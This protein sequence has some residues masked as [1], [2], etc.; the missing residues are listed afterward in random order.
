MTSRP[1]GLWCRRN[2][3]IVVLA[4]RHAG[5][6][7]GLPA[8]QRTVARRAEATKIVSPHA[9][10]QT[11]LHLVLCVFDVFFLFSD[12]KSHLQEGSVRGVVELEV[13]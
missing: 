8:L 1:S 4:R 7:P 12:L 10:G 6:D 3:G 2:E 9:L 11:C 13:T 5:V